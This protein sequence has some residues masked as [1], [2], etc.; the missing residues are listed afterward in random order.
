M[1]THKPSPAVYEG[2]GLE[3]FFMIA[4]R[5]YMEPSIT[6]LGIGNIL[7]QD[8]GAGVH[9][10][11]LFNG[12]Y[13]VP[14][15]VAI[16]DGGASGLDLMEYLE[17][18]DK[19]LI[20]DAVNFGK[21]PGYIGV[22]EN[23]EIPAHIGMKASMHH[24]GLLDVLSVLKLMDALPKNI[25]L[26]GIQPKSMEPGLDMTEDIW[27]KV[28]VLSDMIADKLREWRVPCVLRSHRRSY[29]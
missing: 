23:E 27:D 4:R 21:E 29:R 15:Y 3:G 7:M 18:R 10:I 19:V 11:R 26:V 1:Y 24:L 14:D 17:N 2:C 22:L 28:I 9:T 8:E 13:S 20:A 6:V 12:I 5:V 25:C 16:I